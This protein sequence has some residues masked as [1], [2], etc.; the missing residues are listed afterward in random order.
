MQSNICKVQNKKYLNIAVLLC[1]ATGALNLN[2]LS[3]TKTFHK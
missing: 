3:D 1:I 2:K